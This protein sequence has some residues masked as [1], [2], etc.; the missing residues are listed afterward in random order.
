MAKK[1]IEVQ[2]TTMIEVPMG[3]VTESEYLSTHVES[4][5]KTMP[6]RRAFRRILRGLQ[7]RGAATL[8]GRPVTRPG[9]VLRWMLEQ[10]G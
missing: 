7:E 10:I 9:D 3:T 8:D 5:L 4:K 2:E 6:Q 1:T